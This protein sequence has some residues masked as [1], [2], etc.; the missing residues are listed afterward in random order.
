[1]NVRISCI[2][3]SCHIFGCSCG[4]FESVLCQ[5]QKNS[6]KNFDF[7]YLSSKQD[8]R[9]DY[10]TFSDLKTFVSS[11]DINLKQF[12]EVLDKEWEPILE[13]DKWNEESRTFAHVCCL[14]YVHDFHSLYEVRN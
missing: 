9:L 8:D 5:F 11:S 7:I 4:V 10:V 2:D 6:F 14:S 1:M 13:R 3:C 12:L